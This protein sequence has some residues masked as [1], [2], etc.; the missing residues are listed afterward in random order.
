MGLKRKIYEVDD[1]TL[2]NFGAVLDELKFTREKLGVEFTPIYTQAFSSW[3]KAN[4][5]HP[6]SRAFTYGNIRTLISE[7]NKWIG[8]RYRPTAGLRRTRR[9]RFRDISPDTDGVRRI[10]MFTEDS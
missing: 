8:R 9:T 10:L 4:K 1:L 7:L 2:L 3:Y 5:H 6:V